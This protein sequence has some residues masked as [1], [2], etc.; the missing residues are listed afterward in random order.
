MLPGD[1]IAKQEQSRAYASAFASAS[2]KNAADAKYE[3]EN[4][5]NYNGDF[6]ATINLAS[7]IPGLSNAQRAETKKDLQT[8][9]ANKDW[10]SAYTQIQSSTAAKLKGGAAKTFQDQQQSLT[11][12][13]DMDA[14]LTELHDAGYDTNKLT[15]TA[16]Q[17]QTKIGLLATD[18]KYAQVAT[19]VNSAFQQYRQNM[20]GAAFGAKESAEYASVLPSIGNTFELNKAKIAGAKDYLNGQIEGAIRNNIGQGGVEIK[21]YAEGAGTAVDPTTAVN[22]YVVEHPE[23]ADNV[24]Q[25]YELPGWTD[26]DVLD[27]L[28]SIKP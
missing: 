28:D 14:A 22:N 15:G 3:A 10:S 24:A 26:Q 12:V 25:L 17:I 23:E 2:G 11:A 20:T 19:H 18:P 21:K 16:E 27:Y 4:A 8:F 6:E 7:N 13:Q 5:S 1:W 9:I